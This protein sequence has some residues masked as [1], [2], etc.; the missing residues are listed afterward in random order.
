M[1]PAKNGGKNCT[2][3]SDE[4]L[5]C[6]ELEYIATTFLTTVA[7]AS[8]E[9]EEGDDLPPQK[10]K[11]TGS[12]TA[13]GEV[14]CVRPHVDTHGNVRMAGKPCPIRRTK[15]EVEVFDAIKVA[16]SRVKRNVAS[17]KN[18]DIL[19]LIDESKS[20]G[21]SRFP[22][23]L[24]LVKAIT[25]SLC[26]SI[27]IKKDLTRVGILTFD[28]TQHPQMDFDDYFQRA[29]MI[30]HMDTNVN[31]TDETSGETCL[32]DA[33]SYVRDEMFVSKRGARVGITDT[34]R[35]VILMTDGCTN[36]R[37]QGD[38]STVLLQMRQQFTRDRI[39]VITFYVGSDSNCV[40]I[41]S[42]LADGSRCYQV[43]RAMDFD[44]LDAISAAI[45]RNECM[46]AWKFE[47]SC[48]A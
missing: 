27:R 25:N 29:Q 10:R 30:D 46:D 34:E 12:S 24:R 31:Y 35:V 32:V 15:R 48:A 40:R 11:P 36:C 16:N 45:E 28:R 42:G 17:T 44:E 2:G 4:Y 7:A 41:M 3:D 8:P 37:D 18:R 5:P 9:D 19:F 23:F 38:L 33:L 22:K 26:G 20:V 21:S 13:P 47:P 1:I 14:T 43:F 39:P 6:T